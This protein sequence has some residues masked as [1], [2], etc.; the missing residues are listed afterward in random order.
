MSVRLQTGR[1]SATPLARMHFM[2]CPNTFEPHLFGY[3]PFD[4]FSQIASASGIDQLARICQVDVSGVERLSGKAG[5]TNIGRFAHSVR[6]CIATFGCCPA[7]LL[8]CTSYFHVQPLVN[9]QSS[10]L[11]CLVLI[12]ADQALAHRAF[13]KLINNLIDAS[14]KTSA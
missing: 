6:S 4:I 2:Q 7:V 8:R 13:V 5:S 9:I 10:R 1:V 3:F 14:F 12:P 11:L